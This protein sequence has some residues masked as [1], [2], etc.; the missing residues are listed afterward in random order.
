MSRRVRLAPCPVRRAGGPAWAV[1][2]LL[3]A[4]CAGRQ[5][6]AAPACEPVVGGLASDAAAARLAGQYG[7]TVVATSGDETGGRSVGRL[8]L[9]RQDS[10][11]W[12]VGMPG[13]V[14]D[15]SAWA[16]LYGATDV[17]LATVGALRLGDLMSRDPTKPGV[18]VLERR[19]EADVPPSIVLRLGSLANQRDVVR[20]DGGYTALRVRDITAHGFRG[21]WASGTMGAQAEGYFCAVRIDDS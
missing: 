5:Q 21:S 10:S 17:D 12:T 18:L 15:T 13:G 19:A 8:W 7:L 20:F 3:S 16:P 14:P 9:M 6:A 11:L 2:L 4:A 1:C